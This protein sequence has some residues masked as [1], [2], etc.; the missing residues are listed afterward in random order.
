MSDCLGFDPVMA[1]NLPEPFILLAHRGYDSDTIR[2]TLQARD[3]VPVIP[4]RKTRKLHV[5]ADRQ[6]CR[7]RNLDEWCFNKLKNARRPATRL[8]TRPS[9][10]FSASSTLR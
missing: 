4:T 7:M 2:K 1:D 9:R 5:A 3:V 6:L 8:A 10:A